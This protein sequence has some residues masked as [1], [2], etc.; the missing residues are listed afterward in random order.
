MTR[1]PRSD[2]V[3]RVALSALSGA[4]FLLL[5]A[6]LGGPMPPA[7]AGSAEPRAEGAEPSEAGH[8][9]EV[10][11]GERL[12]L[13]TRFAQFFF[14]NA[15]GDANAPLSAGDPVRWVRPPPRS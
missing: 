6:A 5:G 9:A 15:G 8:L 13:E 14:A 11:I 7:G 12:F 2:R 4:L 10:A 3:R 1:I